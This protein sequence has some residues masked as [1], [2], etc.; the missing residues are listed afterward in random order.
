MRKLVIV[1]SP[2]KSKTIQKYLGDDYEVV[3]SKGH[4]RDLSTKGKGGLGVDIEAGFKPTYIINKDKTDVVKQLKA[5]AKGADEVYLATDPDREGEA[6]SWHLADELGLTLEK[7]NRVVFN[8]ITKPAIQEAF[9][10]PRQVDMDLVKSQETRRILDRIIGF[11]LSTLLQKKIGSKSA[12]RVQSVALKL[13][14]EKENEIKAFVPEEKWTIKAQFEKDSIEFDAELT[15]AN[16]KSLKLKNKADNDAIMSR[17]DPF[18]TVKSVDEKSGIKAHKFPFTTSTLQQEAANK[19]NFAAK[20]TMRVAQSLYEGINLKDGQE[21]IITYMRTDSTRLSE[22]FVKDTQDLIRK[23]YGASYVGHYKLKQDE[24][25]Q[26]AHEAVRPTHI[27]YTPESLKDYLSPDEFR[28]YALIYA[29]TMASLMSA[30]KTKTITAI[31]NQK[32]YDFTAKGT[33]LEFDGYLK[34][35]QKYESSSD[36]WLP[37]LNIGEVLESKKTEGTQSFSNPPLR[38][39]EARLIDAM[40]QKG[41]GRPSTYAAILDTIESRA[42]VTLEKAEGAK[43]KVF[44]PT[45]QGFLTTNKLDEY[46]TNIINVDYTAM[47]E[48]ELDQIAEAALE[49]RKALEDFYQAFQPLYDAALNNMEK[50]QPVKTGRICPDCGG[51]LVQRKGR[52]GVFVACGNYPK[53]KYVEKSESDVKKEPEFT[54]E[55]CPDCGK[56]LVKRM[57]RFGKPFVGCT[58]Y[59]S[60]KYIQNSKATTKVEEPTGEICPN[61]GQPLVHKMGRFGPF[62]ACSNYPTCK[63]IQPKAKKNDT[64]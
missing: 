47:M 46:F 62:I 35:Y 51:E 27:D 12:G 16:G 17:L 8:E 50:I 41:I 14:V 48:A 55:N 33:K 43:T 28:L 19:L 25:S 22:G 61:C 13:I 29:R 32:D 30:P 60:C 44:I 39:S 23:T 6:I 4:I 53:C 36:K 15:H 40:E 45:E 11:R 5:K 2:S 59:P 10:H 49:G 24:N 9:S 21:G 56:P 1:E 34:V 38:Y 31:L 57:N 20:K 37:L 54:G 52:F 7:S 42:Y 18:F 26:D 64:K 58:G 3:S 63:Y